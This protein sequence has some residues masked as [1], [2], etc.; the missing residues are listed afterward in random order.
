MWTQ[1]GIL[2]NTVITKSGLLINTRPTSKELVWSDLQTHFPVFTY[3]HEIFL[4]SVLSDAFDMLPSILII[5]CTP[6]EQQII[7]SNDSDIAHNCPYGS[8]TSYFVRGAVGWSWVMFSASDGPG[9]WHMREWRIQSTLCLLYLLIR[10]LS[11]LSSKDIL[12]RATVKQIT[13]TYWLWVKNW[14]LCY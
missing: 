6:S 3:F 9:F 5:T 14:G 1:T 11:I 13:G 4:F 7:Y 12:P 8:L 10:V 2:S